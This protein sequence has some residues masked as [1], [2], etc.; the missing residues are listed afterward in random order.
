MFSL[1]SVKTF[2]LLAALTA[3]VLWIGQ[4]LGGKAGLM[5]ALSLAAAMNLGSYWFADRLILRTYNAQEVTAAESPRL[6]ATVSDLA[7]RAGLP[8]PRV[9]L[10]PEAA[11]NAFATGRNAKHGVVA[12]TEGLLGGLDSREVAAVIAHELGH[13]ENRDTLIMSVAAALAG[14]LSMVANASMWGSLFGG[15]RADEE[16]GGSPFG[17]FLAMLAAPVAASLVQMSI[18]RSREFLADE[19][20]AR[21][22]GDPLA[23]A[24]A[25]RKI[26]ASSHSIPMEAGSPAMAH[27][28]IHNP[29]SLEGIASLFSTHP[30]VGERV[31]RLERMAEVP[32][33]WAA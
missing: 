31:A 24:G 20:A 26:E 19:A 29:F 28:F 23:L 25:L 8:M 4:A 13:I 27:M 10:I 9:Y 16:E 22:T 7:N 15:S 30:P 11:P 32:R 6:Y 17:G 1:N 21:I 5:L 33:Q 2:T 18:S 14:A 12:V 3:L